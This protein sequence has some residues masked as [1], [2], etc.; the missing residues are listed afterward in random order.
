M[1]KLSNG[2]EISEDTVVSALKKAGISVEPKP[3]KHVFE[4]GDVVEPP[5][6]EKRII[7]KVGGDLR[8]FGLDGRQRAS[9]Y[10]GIKNFDGCNYKYVCKLSDIVI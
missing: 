6:K 8:A 4:A 3:K 1:I 2:V 10:S 9:Q 5:W 7:I